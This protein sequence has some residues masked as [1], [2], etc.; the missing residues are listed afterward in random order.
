MITHS[1][2]KSHMDPPVWL[3]ITALNYSSGGNYVPVKI[4]DNGDLTA[5][6]VK[7]PTMETYLW[8]NGEVRLYRRLTD[9]CKACRSKL[10]GSCYQRFRDSGC[11]KFKNGAV[12]FTDVEKL[13]PKIRELVSD[14]MV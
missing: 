5:S 1:S 6:S 10:Q 12:F 8:F 13:P 14:K 7:R 4:R 11:H 9:A 2:L 3:V